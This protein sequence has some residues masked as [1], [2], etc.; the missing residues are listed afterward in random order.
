MHFAPHLLLRT[1]AAASRAGALL[2]AGG[3]I[4]S[5]IDDDGLAEQLAGAAHVDGLVVELPALA[6][7]QF[8]RKLAARY[9]EGNLLVLAIT[10][11]LQ[12]VQ[13]AVPSM[14]ALTPREVED[15]LISTI[16]L[17]LAARGASAL[18]PVIGAVL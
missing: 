11:T 2:R 17:A 18:A 7:I 15:D 14:L 5:R 13:R 16:D 9:G 8:G 1:D 4:V 10:S 3:Y 6:T 12:T